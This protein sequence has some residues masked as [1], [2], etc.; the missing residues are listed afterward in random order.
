MYCLH[1]MNPPRLQL[2]V[3]TP[4]RSSDPNY[5]VTAACLARVCPCYGASDPNCEVVATGQNRVRETG[6]VVTARRSRVVVA[7]Y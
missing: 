4:S 5:E 6:V 2:S 7:A 1:Q 3:H